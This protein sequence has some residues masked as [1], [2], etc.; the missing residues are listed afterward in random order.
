MVCV[1]QYNNDVQSIV[2]YVL[3]L[4]GAHRRGKKE[5]EDCAPL[6]FFSPL[7]NLGLFLVVGSNNKSS[8]KTI[9]K[10][11]HLTSTTIKN[12]FRRFLGRIS[13]ETCL[14]MDYFGSRLYP[15]SRQTLEDR[16]QTPV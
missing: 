10:M 5:Q 3:R 13:A 12:K 4:K 1:Q 7:D 2:V 16:P 15:Q 14:K 11:L 9:A 8:N 6:E